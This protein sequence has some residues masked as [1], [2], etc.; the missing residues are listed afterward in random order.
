MTKEQLDKLGN[1]AKEIKLNKE[2]EVELSKELQDAVAGGVSPGDE[3]E[4]GI[5]VN[6]YQC[7][8]K[9]LPK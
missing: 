2:G 9:V 3:E 7:A 5:V 1:I 6:V 8:C 4:E